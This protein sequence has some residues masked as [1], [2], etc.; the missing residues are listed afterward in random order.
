MN[1]VFSIL[2]LSLSFSLYAAD[3]CVGCKKALPGMPGNAAIDEVAGL[4]KVAGD[5][6]KKFGRDLCFLMVNAD[7]TGK[8]IVK[9]MEDQMLTHMKISRQ[10][11]DYKDKIISFWNANKNDFICHGKVHSGTRETEHLMKRA[12]ALWIHNKVLTGFLLKSRAVDVN[13][14]EYVDGKAETVLDY[15]DKIIA[16]PKFTDKYVKSDILRLQKVLEKVFNGKRAHEL[17]V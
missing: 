3:D 9:V 14:I 1:R 5:P 4:G 16:D 7:A 13:A 11:P 10:T 6:M 12:I 2:L 8:D 15:L 17:N